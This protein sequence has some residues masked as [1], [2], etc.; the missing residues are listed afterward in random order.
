MVGI[1]FIKKPNYDLRIHYILII[2]LFLI[3]GISLIN[4]QNIKGKNPV[5]VD[6]KWV[7][8]NSSDPGIVILH[9]SSIVRN[10]QNGHIPGSWFLYP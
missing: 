7:E 2:M 9:I 3:S 1:H 6:C 8:E 10:Y 4:A 5:L